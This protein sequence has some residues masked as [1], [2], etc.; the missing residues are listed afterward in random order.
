MISGHFNTILAQYNKTHIRLGS[1]KLRVKIYLK[2]NYPI[3]RH[4]IK[5]FVTKNWLNVNH[6]LRA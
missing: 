4:K 6:L 3:D 5:H 2:K 1:G